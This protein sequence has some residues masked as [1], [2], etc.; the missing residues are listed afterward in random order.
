MNK[1][2][3]CECNKIAVW[4]YM[5]HCNEKTLEGFYCD[6]CV[7][8]GC[9]CNVYALEE[10]DITDK[11]CNI[12]FYDK[13]ESH[14]NDENMYN[15]KQDTSFYFEYLDEKGRRFPCCE[16]DYCEDGYDLEIWEEIKK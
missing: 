8:R 12:G 1:V 2:K 7:P 4:S 15:E 11:K 3:C 10:F 14:F 9:T 16:Y 6:D 5:P 13:N